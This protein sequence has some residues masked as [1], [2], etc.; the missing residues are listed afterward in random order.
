MLLHTNKRKGESLIG[1]KNL[2]VRRQSVR[3]AG[4]KQIVTRSY[5]I[6][7]FWWHVLKQPLHH[8]EKLEIYQEKQKSKLQKDMLSHP[9]WAT[10]VL[11]CQNFP[12]QS[13]FSN[14]IT[15][16][17]SH[18]LY[19][20]SETLKCTTMMGKI[21]G[22]DRRE[23]TSCLMMVSL[24]LAHQNSLQRCEPPPIYREPFLYAS[25]K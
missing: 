4:E 5:L 20:I 1:Q 22:E 7:I 3:Q 16:E 8:W 9:K 10:L 18:R 17:K 2:G 21:P 13:C 12:E 14:I 25:L 19:S 11:D 23:E 6:F 24:G 15:Q